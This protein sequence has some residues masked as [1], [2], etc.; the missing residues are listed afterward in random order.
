MFEDYPLK[1]PAL[2]APLKEHKLLKAE[3]LNETDAHI[4]K[5]F[6]EWMGDLTHGLACVPERVCMGRW[7]DLPVVYGQHRG[8]DYSGDFNVSSNLKEYH[9]VDSANVL[10]ELD[11]GEWSFNG[12]DGFLW[13]PLF[14][15]SGTVNLFTTTIELE[16]HDISAL[17]DAID[18]ALG[19]GTL[20][21]YD[22]YFTVEFGGLEKIPNVAVREVIKDY[23]K[24]FE[25]HQ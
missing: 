8:F 12:G 22:T 21:E 9:I 6:N 17:E 11:P 18:Q 13:E 24:N 7:R 20:E 10:E 3:E 19:S 2:I 25:R 1:L 4:W 5:N 16:G 14:E 15:G 23:R